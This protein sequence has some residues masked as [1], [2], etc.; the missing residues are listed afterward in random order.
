ME[1]IVLEFYQALFTSQSPENF[2]EILAQIPQVVIAEMNNDLLAEFKVDEVETALK[3]M[4]P[5][6]SPR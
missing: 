4:A 6:K 2:D 5:L 3:Q 1:D